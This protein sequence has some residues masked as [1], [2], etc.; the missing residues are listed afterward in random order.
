MS[1]Q[2]RLPDERGWA[3][4]LGWLVVIWALSVG[5]LALVAA[6]LKGVMRLVGMSS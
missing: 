1:D 5:A 6:S 4:R 2:R 3:R